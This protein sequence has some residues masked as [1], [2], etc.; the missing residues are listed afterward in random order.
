MQQHARAAASRITERGRAEAEALKALVHEYKAAGP[1]AREVLVLQQLMPM[2]TAISGATR[3]TK[4][5]EWTVL[6]DDDGDGGMAGKA[7]KFNERIR[8]ATGV[9]LAKVAQNMG[10]PGTRTPKTPPPPK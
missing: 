8:A 1:A 2:L 3:K 6:S 7:I 9:D 10:G 5:A 4:I